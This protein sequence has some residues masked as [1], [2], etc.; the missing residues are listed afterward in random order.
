LSDPDQSNSM[1][2]TREGNS[3]KEAFPFGKE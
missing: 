3:E 1:G 2:N